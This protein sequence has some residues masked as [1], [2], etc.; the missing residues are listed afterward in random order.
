MLWLTLKYQTLTKNTRKIIEK[1]NLWGQYQYIKN[2]S[3]MDNF[4]IVY[5]I[6]NVPYDM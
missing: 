3:I 2:K 5:G 4:G 1:I 6:N